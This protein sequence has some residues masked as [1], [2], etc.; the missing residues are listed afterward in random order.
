MELRNLFLFVD[1]F[2][3]RRDYIVIVVSFCVF[4]EASANPNHGWIKMIKTAG[5]LTH[6]DI[7]GMWQTKGSQACFVLEER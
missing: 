2:L 3:K 1:T 5:F 4:S 7:P 6:Q